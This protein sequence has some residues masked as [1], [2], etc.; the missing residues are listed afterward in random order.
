MKKE[1]FYTDISLL[2]GRLIQSLDYKICL[3]HGLYNNNTELL[4]ILSRIAFDKNNDFIDL[5]KITNG[6]FLENAARRITENIF[7]EFFSNIE[8]LLQFYVGFDLEQ[9]NI[10]QLDF[11]RLNSKTQNYPFNALS[12]HFLDNKIFMSDSKLCGIVNRFKLYADIRNCL[13]HSFGRVTENRKLMIDKLNYKIGEVCKTE[14][15]NYHDLISDIREFNKRFKI[16][17]N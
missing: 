8:V 6:A 5:L 16:V 15:L 14:D 2:I 7:I 11:Y 13:L 4:N 3:E 1:D 9:C 10:D 17:M 12:T